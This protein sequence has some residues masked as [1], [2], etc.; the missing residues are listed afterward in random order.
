MAAPGTCP[1]K[2]AAS[3]AI[4]EQESN[5]VAGRKRST[6]QEQ[7]KQN[8]WNVSWLNFSPSWSSSRLSQALRIASSN[9][10]YKL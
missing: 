10:C 8:P 9:K 4:L 5:A 3:M 2:K 1:G 6:Q 7:T